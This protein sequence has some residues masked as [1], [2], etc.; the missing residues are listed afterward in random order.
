MVI[1]LLITDDHELVRAGLVQYLSMSPDIKVVAEAS[2]GNE[3]LQK[4]HTGIPD[5]LLLDLS[6]PG[7]SGV[8]LISHIKSAYPDLL[9]LVLSMHNDVKTVLQAM[10]AGASGFICKDCSPQ[11]LLEAIRKVVATGK[12]LNPLMAEQLAYASTSAGTTDIE[13]I[14]SD[15]ELEIYR[16]IVEG[17]SIN[18]IASQLYISSK[19]VSTH[20]SHLLTKLGLKNIAELVRYAM[21]NNYFNDIPIGHSDVSQTRIQQQPELRCADS[22][23]EA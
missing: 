12:Y 18:E 3:L 13:F 21:D 11:I 19:T 4:L 10:K 16:M 17:K 8:A 2:N 20:K 22:G 15:R 9:I 5:L 7:E 14:L 1:R 6:M 23:E